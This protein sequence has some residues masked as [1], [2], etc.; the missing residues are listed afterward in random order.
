MHSSSSSSSA[1]DGRIQVKRWQQLPLQPL[2]KLALAK[3]LLCR[4]RVVLTRQRQG[5]A[6]GLLMLAQ[7]QQIGQA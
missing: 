2:V 1:A 4:R 7:Q 5:L 6:A 3:L